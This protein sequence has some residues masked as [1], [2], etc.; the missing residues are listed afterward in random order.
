MYLTCTGIGKGLRN[1]HC[2]DPGGKHLLETAPEKELDTGPE[3][4][5]APPKGVMADEPPNGVRVWLK[6][7]APDADEEGGG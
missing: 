1:Q 3:K 2:N 6:F 7:T 4:D 5:D